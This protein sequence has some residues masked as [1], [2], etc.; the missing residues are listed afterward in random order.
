MPDLPVPN[1]DDFPCLDGKVTKA[2]IE[3]KGTGKFKAEYVPWM[4]IMALLDTL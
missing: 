4:K 2:D 3:A 1:W